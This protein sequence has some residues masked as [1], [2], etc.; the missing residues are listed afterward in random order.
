MLKNT[1][2]IKILDLHAV[3]DMS[4]INELIQTSLGQLRD[5]TITA[6]ESLLVEVDGKF[7]LKLLEILMQDGGAD[8]VPLFI[9]SIRHEK[10]TLYAKSQILL[11]R[12]FKHQE[13]L[14]ALLSIEN[15]IDAEQRP[16]YQRVLGRM[17]S[18]FS[19]QFYMSE[20]R[21]GY[22]NRRRTE[23]A[24]D[25]MLRSPHADYIPFLNEQILQNDAGFR[26]EGLR[27]LRE[28][29]DTTSVEQMFT[30]LS[31]LRIQRDKAR[32]LDGLIRAEHGEPDAFFRK[33]NQ[34][35]G[36]NWSAPQEAQFS[37]SLARGEVNDL[38][39]QVMGGFLL[40]EDVHRKIRPLLR[41]RLSGRVS[42]AFDESR[43]QQTMT[44]YLEELE[45][46]LHF[47]VASM[48]TISQRIEDEMFV[49]RMEQYLPLNDPDRDR[50]LISTLSGFQSDESAALLKEYV[51]TVDD[52][53][54][55]ALSM[56]AL[57]N[58]EA[59]EIPPGVQKFCED[60]QN[61]ILRK[62]AMTLLG[63]WE[64]GENLI[65]K[66]MDNP[67]IAVR[68][69]ALQTAAAYKLTGTRDNIL[70]LLKPNLPD[71]VLLAAVEAIRV[72]PSEQTGKSV[73]PFIAPPHGLKIRQAALETAFKAAGDDGLDTL[74]KMFSQDQGSKLGDVSETL[75][76]LI[77][78]DDLAA[79]QDTLLKHKDYFLDLFTQSND[80]AT[81]NRILQM[82]E[83][84]EIT[85]EY[86]LRTLFSG[87][88]KVMRSFKGQSE[89]EEAFRCRKLAERLENLTKTRNVAAQRTRLLDS[90]LDTVEKHQGFPKVQALRKLGQNYRSDLI[91]NNPIGLQRMLGLVG[92][93][94]GDETTEVRLQAIAVAGKIR[95][96]RLHK[97][98]RTMTANHRGAALNSIN[99][100]LRTPVD[101]IF[102]KPIKS[103]FVMDDSRYVTKQLSKVLAQAGYQVDF[104]TKVHAG[105]ARLDEGEGFDL[106]I[107]D[108]IMPEMDGVTFLKQARTKET[109]PERVIVITSTR[110]QDELRD[111][112]QI[113]IDG[114]MLKPFKM[115]DLIQRIR[116]L[117]NAVHDTG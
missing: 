52:P 57:K 102:I 79:N 67:S 81:R 87:L 48:G 8:L 29:G 32:A 65:A 3:G 49:R 1:L 62:K 47:N 33:L 7:R 36:L 55:L 30:L 73:R 18:Q 97:V 106:L 61:A 6:L 27:I 86:H 50:L 63:E 15:D 46:L 92:D 95:H 77:L 104:E 110:N 24:A 13:A 4:R 107:L 51:N 76:Q 44:E 28:L 5:K 34:Q 84:M 105:L 37:E 21:S 70:K 101:P 111:F 64:L 99:N 116:D 40:F 9:N 96:P 25:M 26:H 20:F 88:Q 17:L 108:Y 90:L 71:S 72:F 10:N 85:E 16:T 89:N 22:G 11:F 114:L 66:A 109:A 43:A 69:D 78:N 42:S 91:S 23:F 39:E 103:I 115:E 14:P 31:K 74:L 68:V 45:Q 35:A 54:L 60:E 83:N 94:L 93:A 112:L 113:G 80:P 12:E 53:E 2:K 38:L 82:F 41:D 98:L 58:F 56:D 19:E 100:A 59:T 117:S 75:L